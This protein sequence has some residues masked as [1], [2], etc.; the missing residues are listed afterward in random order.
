M[1]RVLTSLYPK[2]QWTPTHSEDAALLKSSCRNVVAIFGWG[3]P[4]SATR[5]NICDYFTDTSVRSSFF[6]TLPC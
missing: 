1:Y 3:T 2:P 4:S 5:N 6:Y